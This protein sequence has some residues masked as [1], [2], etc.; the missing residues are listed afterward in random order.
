MLH[1]TQ[2]PAFVVLHISQLHSSRAAG[3]SGIFSWAHNWFVTHLPF[4]FMSCQRGK[5]GVLTRQILTLLSLIRSVSGSS[6]GSTR[7][8]KATNIEEASAKLQLVVNGLSRAAKPPLRW[9]ASATFQLKGSHCA[10]SPLAPIN[11]YGEK[12]EGAT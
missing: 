9:G 8:K 6:N 5:E 4:P 10:C 2:V 11:K 1:S 12:H 3:R 7:C